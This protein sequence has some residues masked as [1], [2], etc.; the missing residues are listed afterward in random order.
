MS[1]WTRRDLLR[2]AT[3]AATA[4]A[5]PAVALRGGAALAA[6]APD[7]R[8]TDELDSFDFDSI[9]AGEPVMVFVHDA[10]HG[11]ASILQGTS[12]TVVRD[13]RLVAKIMRSG[14]ARE[15]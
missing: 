5:M 12:E 11:D 1:E 9:P 2:G 14:T 6:G 10:R 13:R 4:V 15:V 8:S 7:A 3:V